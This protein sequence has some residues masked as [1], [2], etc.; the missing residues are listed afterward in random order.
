MI[1]EWRLRPHVARTSDGY[2]AW[3]GLIFPNGLHF[4]DGFITFPSNTFLHLHFYK[5][6]SINCD[7]FEGSDGNRASLRAMS[8]GFQSFEATDIRIFY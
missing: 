6:I 1:L 5:S 7:R 4:G 3:F 8:V 2:H